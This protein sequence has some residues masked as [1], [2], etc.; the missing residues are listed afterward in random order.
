MRRLLIGAIA[1]ALLAAAPVALRAALQQTSGEGYRTATFAAG[2][3]WCMEPPFDELPGVISTTSG[4]TGGRTKNPTYAEVSAGH[5]AHAEA[6]AVVYDPARISYEQLLQVF[7]KNIDPI[8]PNRQFCD[9]RRSTGRR[10]SITVTNRRRSRSNRSG[11]SKAQA[12]S[13]D[14]S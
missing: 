10:S 13:T 11:P 5:T 6:V 14:R 12:A 9:V 8:T 3:F 2:C 7:W 4:Y 1:C